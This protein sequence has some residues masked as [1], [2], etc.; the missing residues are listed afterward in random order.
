MVSPYGFSVL[1]YCEIAPHKTTRAHRDVRE[2][3]VKNLTSDVVE[4]QVDT[5]R[6]RRSQSPRQVWFAV[7]EEFIEAEFLDDL[8]ALLGSTRDAHHLGRAVGLGDLANRRSRR[9]GGAGHDD[10][11]AGFE[12]TDFRQPEEGRDARDTDDVHYR[13]QIESH[14][15]WQN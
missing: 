5:V 1:L 2:H 6:T 10:D 9:A 13:R 8:R 14:A 3:G 11:V 7:I 15:R 12:L 4:V